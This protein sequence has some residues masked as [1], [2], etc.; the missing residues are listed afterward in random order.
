MRDLVQNLIKFR[1]FYN[2]K[3]KP[4]SLI[5]LKFDKFKMIAS[6]D[7]AILLASLHDINLI[8]QI[9]FFATFLVSY[10]V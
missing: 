4:N 1:L 2:P 10:K 9:C 7:F 3:T 6:F 8:A 5:F